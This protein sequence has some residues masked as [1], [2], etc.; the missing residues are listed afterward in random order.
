M[1]EE[2]SKP[3]TEKKS[4]AKAEP[5]MVKVKVLRRNAKS[6]VVEH[7]T[8]KGPVHLIVPNAA[9][10]NGG[11]SEEDVRRAVWATE[12]WENLLKPVIDPETIYAEIAKDLRVNGIHTRE[13]FR[14][15]PQ[16]VVNAVM[17]CIRATLPDLRQAVS[18]AD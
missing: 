5:K 6:S 14:T 18:Q 10:A 4:K 3:K 11:L 1:A 12:D 9:V 2:E 8:D 13:D 7:D 16:V 17:R 15:K